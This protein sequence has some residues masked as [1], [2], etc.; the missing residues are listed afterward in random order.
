MFVPHTYAASRVRRHGATMRCRVRLALVLFVGLLPATPTLAASSAPRI[1]G[2]T[3]RPAPVAAVQTSGSTRTVTGTSATRVFE[4]EFADSPTIPR[5]YRQGHTAT[6]LQDGRV[7]VVGG[8][9]DGVYLNSAEVYDPATNTWTLT[10]TLRQP[11]RD[12]TAT[13]LQD[14]KVLIVGGQAGGPLSSAEVYDP[15]TGAFTFAAPI[16]FPRYGH[17]ASLLPDGAVLIVGGGGYYDDEGVFVIGYTTAERYDPVTRTWADVASISYGRAFHTAT[18]LD[19]GK[20]LVAGGMYRD[21]P[22]DDN[23]TPTIEVYDPT[24]GRWTLAAY[25]LSARYNHTATRLTDGRVLIAGGSDDVFPLTDAELFDPATGTRTRIDSLE[26]GRAKHTATLLNDGTV[27]ISGGATESSHPYTIPNVERYDPTT[28]TWSNSG[29]LSHAREEHTATL[30]PDGTVMVVGG[31]N[32]GS[33]SIGPVETLASAEFYD[34]NAGTWTLAA[35]TLRSRENGTA[36]RLLDGRVLVAGGGYLNDANFSSNDPVATPGAEVYDSDASTWTTTDSMDSTREDHAATVLN[37]G[38]VLVAG[39]YTGGY[40][41]DTLASVEVYDPDT[42]TF[43]LADDLQQARRNHTATT[44]ADGRVLVVG[45][46]DGAAALRSAELRDPDTG[47]WTLATNLRTRRSNHTA[48][49]LADGT[50]LVVGGFDGNQ[51]LTSAEVYD[52]AANTWSSTGTLTFAHSNHTATLL[53]SGKVLVASGGNAEVYNPATRTFAR[54]GALQTERVH[55]TATALPDGTVLI[56]GGYDFDND[57][58]EGYIW[59]SVELYDPATNAFSDIGG[60]Q[61]ARDQHTATL[62]PDGSVLVVGG[63]NTSSPLRP[64]RGMFRSNTFTGTLTLPTGWLTATTVLTITGATSGAPLVE[65]AINDEPPFLIR[66]GQAVTTTLRNMLDGDNQ[67]L[68]LRLRDIK[69]GSAVVLTTTANI[70]LNGP[71][72]VLTPLPPTS[73]ASFKIQWGGGDGGSGITSYD[74]EV[75][76]GAEGAW[77]PLLTG[78]TARETMFRGERGTTYFFRIRARDVAGNIGS[79]SDI[80]STTVD[81]TPPT[82]RMQELPATSPITIPLQWQGW[83]QSSPVTGYDLDVRDGSDGT[84]TPILTDTTA[85][86][87]TFVGQPNHT[88]YF[89]LRARDEAGN[90]EDWPSPFDTE[91]EVDTTIPTVSDFSINWGARAT[92]DGYLY[93][94]VEGADTQSSVT[95]ARVWGN[96]AWQPWRVIGWQELTL[97]KPD[98]PKEVRAQVRD[99]VGNVSEIVTRTIRLDT[100]A[101]TAQTLSINNGALYTNVPTVTLRIGGPVDAYQMQVSN[102]GGFEDASWQPFDSRLAWTLSTYE[103]YVLPRT[104]YVR[105]K[106]PGDIITSSVGDDIVYDPVAPS[107]SVEITG[108]SSSSLAV[109]LQA[110][111]PDNLSGVAHMRLSTDPQFAGAKWQPYATSATVPRVGGATRVFAQF[112]DGAGNPSAVRSATPNSSVD[113]Q[114]FLPS[115]AN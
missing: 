54:A 93:L 4:T 43:T 77:M 44:L 57:A 85:L 97:A 3:A 115:I 100:A 84:W 39:G 46:S 103:G 89:R 78:T 10:G 79:W 58:A 109:R 80:C 41:G 112:R 64:E 105:I 82:S 22:L 59:N 71:D 49:L 95:E 70:D 75:R 104:V 52:P 107:G 13:L 14:G 87:T 29:D 30:L 108:V 67:Q 11:R 45:G 47:T 60:L 12:H 106:K 86:T 27:L 25:L 32:R 61:Q 88:Y 15:A 96:G 37:D 68:S 42:E 36:S 50:V 51:S 92:T 31:S 40:N 73:R 63:D 66:E 38:R 19:D 76:D 99:S 110:A 8:T 7:L 69:G 23:I 111:D 94:Y 21:N 90:V 65:G 17:T 1:G 26:N 34:P 91:T 72:S 102:T 18:V 83:D 101:G 2:N 98:G 53:K 55:H 20:V 16:H 62:L 9:R 24:T 33:R 56:T 81:G 35:P 74:L 28:N 114:V 48:T 5:A 113:F 6:V